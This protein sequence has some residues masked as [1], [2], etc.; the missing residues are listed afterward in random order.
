[1]GGLW[2]FGLGGCCQA[3]QTLIGVA[4]S[5]SIFAFRRVVLPQEIARADVRLPASE[6]I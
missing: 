2:A 6:W 5:R 4:G 3:A 1:M